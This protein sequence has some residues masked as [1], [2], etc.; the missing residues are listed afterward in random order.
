MNSVLGQS[1]IYLATPISH[2]DPKAEAFRIA[3]ATRAASI[4]HAAGIPV[5]SPASHGG[6]IASLSSIRQSWDYWER[7]DIPILTCC[8]THLVVLCMEGWE[9]SVG[10]KAEI[11]AAGETGLLLT[12]VSLCRCGKPLRKHKHQDGPAHPDLSVVI[13]L[14]EHGAL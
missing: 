2:E 10:V 13:Q 12:Y 5:F 11:R 1:M 7:V 8:C 9:K 14:W 4:L 6:P 3:T